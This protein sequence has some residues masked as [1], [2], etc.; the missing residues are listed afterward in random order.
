[1][2]R[3]IGAA[4]LIAILATIV[5]AGPP[6]EKLSQLPLAT[7]TAVGPLDSFPYVDAVQGL[8]K[9]IRILD[10][11]NVP[12]FFPTPAPTATAVP[13][14]VSGI[15]QLTL[16]VVAGPGTGSQQAHVVKLTSYPNGFPRI[17]AGGEIATVSYPIP[18]QFGGTG[19]TSY[20]KNAIVIGGYNQ[21]TTSYPD[22]V[23][24]PAQHM[25]GIGTN[26]PNGDAGTKIHL[27][28]NVVSANGFGPN[29]H[30]TNGST[31]HTAGSGMFL[32]FHQN[33]SVMEYRLITAN[34][35]W[36]YTNN[37]FHLGLDES[38][39]FGNSNGGSFTNSFDWTGIPRFRSIISG[40]VG[41]DAT[42]VFSSLGD[43]LTI[44]HGGTERTN[45]TLGGSGIFAATTMDFVNGILYGSDGGFPPA[46]K[47]SIDFVSRLIYDHEENQVAD[48]SASTDT[49]VTFQRDIVM[50]SD[51]LNSNA[52]AIGI[53][54]GTTPGL[55][56]ITLTS[57]GL[58]FWV[59][60][61]PTYDF[62]GLAMRNSSNFDTVFGFEDYA[63]ASINTQYK[64]RSLQPLGTP[65]D[66]VLF[67][68]LTQGVA[69]KTIPLTSNTISGGTAGN[70]ATFDLS[71]NLVSSSR[72]T[73]TQMATGTSG[74]PLIGQ[75]AGDPKYAAI[76]IAA[77]T[78]G[79]LGETRGGTGN[80]SY[81]KD[82]VLLG[83]YGIVDTS[84]PGLAFD[85]RVSPGRLGIGIGN[86]QASVHTHTSAS[87]ANLYQATNGPT[88]ITGGAAFGVDSFGNGILVN[89]GAGKRMQFETGNGQWNIDENGQFNNIN[90]IVG[91]TTAATAILDVTGT[92]RLRN[93]T[94]GIAMFDAIGNLSSNTSYPVPNGSAANTSY[95]ASSQGA[96][97]APIYRQ[98][99]A[100]IMTGNLAVKRLNNGTN[101]SA[102]TFWRGDG[103]WATAGGGTS[104]V[105]WKGYHA[106]DCTWSNTST[107]FGDASAVDASCTFTESINSGFGTVASYNDGTPGNNYPGF[108]FTAPET[109]YVSVTA[110]VQALYSS[111]A[112]QYTN[113][114]LAD[115]AGT[116]L[117]EQSGSNL[118]GAGGLP[119]RVMADVIMAVTSGNSYTIKVQFGGT[120]G[121]I[122]VNA[123]SGTPRSTI[124]WSI[125]MVH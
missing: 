95:P 59:P 88:G 117:Q 81:P 49:A 52:P 72:I 89:S 7:P 12:N 36:W 69:N 122:N 25:L 29:I 24:D 67:E 57:G 87:V 94:Q 124:E 37:I 1:M 78:S 6:Y 107:G 19:N 54:E 60:K 66:F 111:I 74:L 100:S 34:K 110:T 2:R 97:A 109:G 112:S 80:T 42:G 108:T 48:Y 93:F 92:A 16:D 35:Q 20:P 31:G 18:P 105:L 30:F 61:S 45:G 113:I 10:L 4:A 55:F 38:G 79:T 125:K 115:G 15:N 50:D 62:Q 123:G 91:G 46:A 58:N 77:A 98:P 23:A 43:P 22:F 32:G 28:Q 17:G 9:R 83:G 102:S 118:G 11:K 8:T 76:D 63:S 39:N 41:A 86:P 84:Y 65:S 70:V 120:A 33:S 101:A 3:W 104:P 103:T 114:R 73:L 116:A 44:T 13:T 96:G 27:D 121:T 90:G 75:G 51:P 26:T 64:F 5:H 56:P 119:S 82:A 106:N 40:I 99:D 53:L 68:N 71:G 47:K 21:Q 85:R 14:T